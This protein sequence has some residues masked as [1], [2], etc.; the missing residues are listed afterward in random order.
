MRKFL[1]I[2]L[3]LLLA[4]CAASCSVTQS[5]ASD[6]FALRASYSAMVLAPAAAYNT[7]PRC[8]VAPQPCSEEQVVRQLRRADAAAKAAL[9]AAEFVARDTPKA[10]A[11]TAINAAKQSV[12]A[13]IEILTIYGVK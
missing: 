3:V 8:D 6:V 11:R 1:S 12:A 2:G 9:D 4:G 13:A 5:P 7:L 10:D